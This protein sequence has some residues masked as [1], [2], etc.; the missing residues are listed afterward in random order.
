MKQ[1]KE[2]YDEVCTQ[3]MKDN[4]QGLETMAL[5]SIEKAQ[6]EMFYYIYKLAEDEK[7]NKTLI[8]FFD[9]LDGKLI[10]Q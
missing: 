1:A 7:D 5:L 8:D 3:C 9:K 4:Y 6:K 10:F 2:I